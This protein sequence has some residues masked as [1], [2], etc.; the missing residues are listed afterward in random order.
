MGRFV[1]YCRAGYEGTGL[2]VAP[3]ARLEVGYVNQAIRGGPN[4]ANRQN[5]ILLSF[6]NLTY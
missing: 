2:A 1:S 6:L 5:H 4:A 3:S